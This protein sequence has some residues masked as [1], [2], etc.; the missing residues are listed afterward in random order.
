MFEARSSSPERKRFLYLR[1]IIDY[2]KTNSHRIAH[3]SLSRTTTP[4]ASRNDIQPLIPIV[5][6]EIVDILT[7][8][9]NSRKT[10]VKSVEFDELIA[11][12]PGDIALNDS[13]TALQ[14]NDVEDVHFIFVTT[15]ILTPELLQ[16]DYS[17][18][19]PH[20]SEITFLETRFDPTSIHK[21]DNPSIY[22]RKVVGQ[23]RQIETSL[24][25][26]PDAE[27]ECGGKYWQGTYNISYWGK[28]HNLTYSVC[29]NCG[30]QRES[31]DNAS[32]I[33]TFLMG[34]SAE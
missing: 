25:E 16:I 21:I 8:D 30:I 26:T 34:L 1:V 27:C 2:L 20:V 15:G 17:S 22:L 12:F 14:G 32:S 28:S 9:P 5:N 4:L 6:G 24:I 19:Y 13:L 3:H 18:Q 33:M 7:L 10:F 29:S 23:I 31:A 11:H